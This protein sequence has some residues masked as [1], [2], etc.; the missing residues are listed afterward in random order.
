MR[1]APLRPPLFLL[2]G[3]QLLQTMPLLG[4]DPSDQ[5]MDQFH[6]LAEL[7]EVQS[8]LDCGGNKIR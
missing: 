7:L 6:V 5:L 8:G 1:V 2:T 3:T 4:F